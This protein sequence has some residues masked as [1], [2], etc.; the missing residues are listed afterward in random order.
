MTS[1]S[2]KLIASLFV[3]AFACP[4][5]ADTIEM[6]SKIS[7]V[8]IYSGAAH[9][10]RTITLD[11]PVGDHTI[12]FDKIVPP[13]DENTLSVTGEGVAAVKIYG[14]YIKQEFLEKSSD[15]RVKDLM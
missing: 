3:V 7:A 8:T 6:P 1:L 11:L 2:R 10:T 4:A 5:F 14:G 13:L 12:I 15:Q 9:L